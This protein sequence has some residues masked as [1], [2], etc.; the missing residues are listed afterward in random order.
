MF[1]VDPLLKIPQIGRHHILGQNP[2]RWPNPSRQADRIIARASPKVGNRHT[3]TD[4]KKIHDLFSL[5]IPVA[6]FLSCPFLGH[7]P[8]DRAVR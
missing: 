6:G 8:G 3:G 4:T 7:N 2:A 5:A 1:L